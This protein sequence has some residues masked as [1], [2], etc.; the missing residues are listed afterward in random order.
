MS[1]ETK[2]RIELFTVI[3]GVVVLFSLP[4][5]LMGVGI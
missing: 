2:A 4:V 5:I 3:I 1:F